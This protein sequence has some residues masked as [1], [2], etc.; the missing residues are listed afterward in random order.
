MKGEDMSQALLNRIS[1]IREEQDTQKRLEMLLELN[2]SLPEIHRLQIPSLITNA[3]VRRALDLIE[4]R[5]SLLS[6]RGKNSSTLASS[7]T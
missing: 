2:D 3:Y 4:E 5:V 7:T 1:R 6:M